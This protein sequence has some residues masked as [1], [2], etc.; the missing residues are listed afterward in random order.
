MSSAIFCSPFSPRAF[1]WIRRKIV[2]ALIAGVGF[3]G[4]QAAPIGGSSSGM[5]SPQLGQSNWSA[6]R[7]ASDDMTKV[8]RRQDLG[9]G[10]TI[11]S[12]EIQKHDDGFPQCCQPA[13]LVGSRSGAVARA[14]FPLPASSI[15][16]C[17]F[18][19]SGSPVHFVPRVMCPIVLGALSGA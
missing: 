10:A 7:A 12:A 15:R 1:Y 9:S 17:G 4:L 19:A 18:P 2:R 5:I 16:T 14:P 11:D 13:D 6:R 8:G 3:R